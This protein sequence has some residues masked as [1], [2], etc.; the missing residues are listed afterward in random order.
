MDFY[1]SV[2]ITCFR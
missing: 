2:A 1:I